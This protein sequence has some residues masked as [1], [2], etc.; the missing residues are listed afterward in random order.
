[1][2]FPLKDF[3]QRFS[4]LFTTHE[5]FRGSD[6]DR[7]GL[8]VYDLSDPFNPE[9]VGFWESGGRGVHRIVYEGGRYAY[10]SATPPEYL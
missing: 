7:A 1:M 9:Q 3:P 6:P 10:L 2:L 4:L 5:H 8:C